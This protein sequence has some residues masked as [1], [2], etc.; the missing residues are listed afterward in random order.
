MMKR[1]AQ[2][3]GFTLLELMVV[4]A[5]IGALLGIATLSVGNNQARDETS[6]FARQ[7]IVLMTTAQEEAVFQ[8]IELGFAVD[9]DALQVLQYQDPLSQEF[10]ANKSAEELTELQQNP[11]Q[12]FQ[13]RALRSEFTA[14]EGVEISLRVEGQ[15][16]DLSALLNQNNGPLPALLFLSSDEYTPFELSLGHTDDP[17][18][19]ISIRGDGMNPPQWEL[20]HYEF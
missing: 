19:S 1:M 2:Q 10:S 17:L 4:L 7:L 14:P 18:F 11:W 9:V 5:I 3:R 15:E 8:N 6:A 12:P 20:N 16:L 13:G